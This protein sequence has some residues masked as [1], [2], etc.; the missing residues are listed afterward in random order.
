MAVDLYLSH[1]SNIVPNN[2]KNLK[3]RIVEL[4]RNVLSYL[5]AEDKRLS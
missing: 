2:V 5:T 3:G 1:I 4:R